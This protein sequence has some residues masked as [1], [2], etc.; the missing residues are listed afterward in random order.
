M[1]SKQKI[2]CR[3]W[4]SLL[5]VVAVILAPPAVAGAETAS[6][7]VNVQVLQT[8][9]LSSDTSVAG[10]S[11]DPS[12]GG[13]ACANRVVV[14]L[15]VLTNSR[16]GYTLYVN[17]ETTGLYNP[18][19]TYEIP[20]VQTAGD[21]DPYAEPSFTNPSFG[22]S[23]DLS[24]GGEFAGADCTLLGDYA[25]ETWNPYSSS[26]VGLC[27]RGGPTPS[28]DVVQLTNEVAVDYDVPAGSYS[29]TIYYTAVVGI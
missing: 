9:T 14:T 7:Q 28:A 16:S 29:D 12:D 27:T 1:G 5:L 6:T 11:V 2:R 21:S 26:A 4:R 22:V 17:D 25:R 18:G 8:L 15:N 23:A 10:L 20:R 24:G 13:A 3:G 19:E